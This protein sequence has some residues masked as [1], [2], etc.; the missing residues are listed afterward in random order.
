MIWLLILKNWFILGW[1]SFYFFKPCKNRIN[2][3]HLLGW[4]SLIP[5]LFLFFSI[6]IIHKTAM[7]F[8]LLV[9]ARLSTLSLLVSHPVNHINNK[10]PDEQWMGNFSEDP[11]ATTSHLLQQASNSTL[12]TLICDSSRG[13]RFC[14]F[15]FEQMACI[16]VY[17]WIKVLGFFLS[18]FL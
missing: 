15:H 4:F 10:R 2:L 8:D 13:S 5:F 11:R 16:I 12:S 6:F 17:C 9:S 14:S 1:F 18:F 7:P 3:I